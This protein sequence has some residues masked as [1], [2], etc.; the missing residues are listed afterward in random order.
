MSQRTGS[1]LRRPIDAVFRPSAIV[2]TPPAY[3]AGSSSRKL[4]LTLQLLAFFILN[5][6]LY[7]LPLSF[8]GIGVVEGSETPPAVVSA[9]VESIGVGDPVS[10]WLFVLR[11]VQ[12]SLFLLTAAV[13]TFV[14]FHIGVRLV[15]GSEGIIRS[16]RVI[17]YSTALYLATIFTLVW[18]ASTHS[19]VAVADRLLIGIQSEFIYFF[20]DLLGSDLGLPSGRQEV[21]S[22]AGLTTTDLGLLS[23]LA[24]AVSYYAYVL[25]LGARKTHDLT[26]LESTLAV[27]FVVLSPALYVIGSILVVELAISIPEVIAV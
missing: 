10:M 9:A 25:Y 23:G 13:I 24:I 6:L 16:L 22:M 21:P 27:S 3:D 2:Q 12:N 7:T 17:T 19:G 20:I 4:W 26:R 11:V 18:L 14:A 1:L 5:L 15:G 8:A